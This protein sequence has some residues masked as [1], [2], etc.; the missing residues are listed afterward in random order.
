MPNLVCDVLSS[1]KL[2][3]LLN[4]KQLG[5]KNVSSVK[6][7]DRDCKRAVSLVPDRKMMIQRI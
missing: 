6:K 3:L 1:F 7:M 5:R 2:K 4:Y